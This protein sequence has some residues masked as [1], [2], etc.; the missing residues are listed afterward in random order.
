MY[1]I[2]E[3]FDLQA[4]ESFE[5]RVFASETKFEYSLRA[6]GGTLICGWYC[7][8]HEGTARVENDLGRNGS[9]SGKILLR[10]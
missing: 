5:S 9:N 10:L 7:N 3:P 1:K 4:I 6:S 8:T 2:S